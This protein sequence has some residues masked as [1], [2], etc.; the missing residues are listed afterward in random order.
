LLLYKKL[1]GQ[2]RGLWR[3]RS[4][5]YFIAAKRELMLNLEKQIILKAI[6]LL[7]E[8]KATKVM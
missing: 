4:T 8:A 6:T 3:R 7:H 2:G 1:D 5:L